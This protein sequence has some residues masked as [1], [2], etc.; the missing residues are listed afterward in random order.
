M[1]SNSLHH[2][3]RPASLLRAILLLTLALGTAGCSDD[4]PTGPGVPESFG[5][6]SSA[7]AG[8]LRLTVSTPQAKVDFGKEVAIRVELT[9]VGD[10]PQIL[11]FLR[12]QPA[13]YPNLTVNVDDKNDLA[14]FVDGDGERDNYTLAAGA[15]I[16]STFTWNQISRLTRDPVEPG[17]YKVIGVVSF[18]DRATLRVDDLFISLN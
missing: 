7:T 10:Q 6:A 16:S 11:D 12:G 8:G 3:L 13:R 5:H 2:R 1:T 18:D 14:H 15:T 4:D 17:V 9:N